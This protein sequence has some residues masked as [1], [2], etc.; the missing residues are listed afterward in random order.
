MKPDV[1]DEPAAVEPAEKIALALGFSIY[2]AD[3]TDP[4]APWHWSAPRGALGEDDHGLRELG[5]HSGDAY[6]SSE[7]AALSA[8]YSLSNALAHWALARAQA[9]FVPYRVS[10][11]DDSD[12]GPHDG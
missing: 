10:L 7:L 6:P 3:L 1:L 4:A 8:L 5:Q 2:Q 12:G 11:E 9:G